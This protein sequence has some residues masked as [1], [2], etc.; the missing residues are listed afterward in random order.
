MTMN[1]CLVVILS[2]I[3][4][5][6]VRNCFTYSS[7][8]IFIWDS[9]KLHSITDIYIYK[10]TRIL[11][12]LDGMKINGRSSNDVS[13]IE[14]HQPRNADELTLIEKQEKIIKA[15]QE[16]EKK[17]ELSKDDAEHVVKGINEF[18]QPKFTNLHFKLHEK[19]DRYYVEVVDQETKEVVREIPAKEL[20][21]M[22]AKMTEFLG[23]FIDQ[24]L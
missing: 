19:L 3:F 14:T 20:L 15:S 17:K 21:D 5:I 24:K 1:S 6:S 13:A 7:T 4:H 16:E 10:S 11:G 23:L 22:H 9:K 18:L 12:E 2:Y 8:K